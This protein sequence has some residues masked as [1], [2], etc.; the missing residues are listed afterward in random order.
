MAFVCCYRPQR[1]WGKVI[2]SQASVILLTGGEGGGGVCGAVLACIAGGTPACL[3]A[4][5]G[6]VCY[7]EGGCL[8]LGVASSQGVGLL[9]WPSV[10]V[11]CYALLV[12][13]PSGMV[14]WGGA[15]GHNRRP[16]HQKA[17]TVA[18]WRPPA[19][20]LPPRTATAAGGTHPTGMY[21]CYN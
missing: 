17:I 11:F 21:S 7:W 10:V 4:G 19:L 1:S 12:W 9:L 2:F 20:P 16:P 6:G 13:W 14:F 18:W 15:E 8:V 3:A 5:L